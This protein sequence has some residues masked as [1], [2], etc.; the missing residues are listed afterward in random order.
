VLEGCAKGIIKTLG[1]EKAEVI[2]ILRDDP[3]LDLLIV[4]TSLRNTV[5]VPLGDSDTI[6]LGEKIVALG[7][8]AGSKATVSKGIIMGVRRRK[9]LDLIEITAPI[10]PGI[11]GGPVFNLSG[12]VIGVATAFLDLREGLNFAM[13]ANYLKTL[14]F[15]RLELGSLPKMTIKLADIERERTSVEVFDIHYDYHLRG[16]HLT[17]VKFAIRNRS[18]YPIRNIRVFFVYKNSLGEVVSYSAKNYEGPVLPKL[19]LLFSNGHAIHY[20]R[21]WDSHYGDWT[22][23]SVEIRILDYEIDRSVRGSPVD[24]I[25]K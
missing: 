11:S 15:S 24:L 18:D 19:P 2:E 23:G 6:T 21:K 25:L 14:K 1:G 17:G 22:E 7:N 10:S 9:G 8:P 3:K 5:P 13:P 4:K 20:F 16:R 12:E